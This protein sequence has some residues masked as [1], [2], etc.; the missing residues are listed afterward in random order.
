MPKHT[1]Y[2]FPTGLA[3]PTDL[4]D[5]PEGAPFVL[6][7]GSG[8]AALY[9]MRG[10][11]WYRINEPALLDLGTP[12]SDGLASA[13][14]NLPGRFDFGAAS[15]AGLAVVHGNLT[16]PVTP[17]S[18]NFNRSDRTLNGDNGWINSTGTAMGFGAG[19]APYTITSNQVK[20]NA[21]TDADPILHVR[22]DSN[23]GVADVTITHSFVTSNGR[24]YLFVCSDLG[25]ANSL[26]FVFTGTAGF[27]DIQRHIGG[28]DVSGHW[29]ANTITAVNGG[30]AAWSA[31][32]S[33]VIRV[34]YTE[35]T[36]TLDVYQNG[37]KKLT[38]STADSNW[39]NAGAGEMPVLTSMPYMGFT[40]EANDRIDDVVCA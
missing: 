34:V 18:D 4:T 15:A 20:S 38:C 24:V 22:N 33:M 10:G 6:D 5:V 37:T 27:H 13:L 30:W 17:F 3:L 19:V 2:R 32:T 36:K 11:N 35:S 14:A 21:S 1:L 39:G 40:S 25:N 9:T 26:R 12:S 31:G 8:N 29:S 7:L 28:D 16:I 23:P